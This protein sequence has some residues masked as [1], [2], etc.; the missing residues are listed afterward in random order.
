MSLSAEMKT[1]IPRYD[2]RV[3]FSD[4]D[5][6]W[7]VSVTELPG[8]M[9]H[10]DSAAEAMGNALEA[11][12]GHLETMVEGGIDVPMPE[13][14]RTFSGDFMVR[15][16]PELHRKLTVMSERS[17]ERSFNRFLVKKLWEIATPSATPKVATGTRVKPKT[18]SFPATKM[19]PAATKKRA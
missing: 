1:W 9:T 12:E 14:M 17:G 8:C 7:V 16:D 2:Y 19:K 13:A 4:E 3:N 15:G 11:V 10:G 18:K 5:E 6:A